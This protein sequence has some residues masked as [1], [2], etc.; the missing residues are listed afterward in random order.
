MRLSII[1][2]STMQMTFKSGEGIVNWGLGEIKC[3]DDIDE[4][5]KTEM[6]GEI[7]KN[8]IAID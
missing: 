2:E 6:T 5:F 1:F 7:K 8:V 4:S 3:N